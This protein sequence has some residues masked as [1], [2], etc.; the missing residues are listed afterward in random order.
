VEKLYGG[1]VEVNKSK[2]QREFVVV[3][4]IALISMALIIAVYATILGTYTGGDV[5][6]VTLSGTIYYSQN[7]TDGWAT[8][9]SNIANGSDWYSRFNIT[10]GGYSGAVTITWWLQKN[11]VNMT[12][13]VEQT[14]SYTLSGGVEAF[15]ASSDGTQ[16][17]N[18]NWGQNAT[19]A[20]TYRV[21]MQVVTA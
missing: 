9:L 15:Y 2:S 17:T 18:Y 12:T 4:L 8:T 10:T 3:T 13:P 6:I 20:D 16:G 7:N 11:Q 1:E 21:K 14:T 19:A 5:T